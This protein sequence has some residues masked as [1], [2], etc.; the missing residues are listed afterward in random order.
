MGGTPTLAELLAA[1]E[2]RPITLG[3]LSADPKGTWEHLSPT[4]VAKSD[5]LCTLHR[6]LQP[7]ADDTNP[8][9]ET[10]EQ[11]VAVAVQL[12]EAWHIECAKVAQFGQA[13]VNAVNARETCARKGITPEDYEQLRSVQLA[14]RVMSQ[15]MYIAPPSTTP[16][17][18]RSQKQRR[19]RQPPSSVK[20]EAPPAPPNTRAS[21]TAGSGA[22]AS[23]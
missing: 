16:A 20:E 15:P 3:P 9:T 11:R 22:N 14:Q 10:A 6:I 4:L 21:K 23:A 17:L 8:A 19:R 18:S 1:A 7:H 13:I 2:A 5:V 12:I